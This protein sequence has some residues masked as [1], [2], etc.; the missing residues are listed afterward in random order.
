MWLCRR[1]ASSS[2]RPCSDCGLRHQQCSNHRQAGGTA[3][4][5]AHRMCGQVLWLPSAWAIDCHRPLL[6]MS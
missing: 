1:T 6:C 4:L 2:R 3:A 5:G